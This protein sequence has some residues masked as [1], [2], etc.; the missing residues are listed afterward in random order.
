MEVC[1]RINNIDYVLMRVRPVELRAAQKYTTYGVPHMYAFLENGDVDW[2]P[3][4]I[5]GWPIVR[6]IA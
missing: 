1:W 5:E 4:C 3:Y 2:F 6:D